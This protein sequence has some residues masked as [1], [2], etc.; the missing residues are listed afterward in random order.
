MEQAIE[1][2]KVAAAAL[3][4][5]DDGRAAPSSGRTSGPSSSGSALKAVGHLP[6]EGTPEVVD[7]DV[8]DLSAVL[9]W[10]GGHPAAVALNYRIPIPRLRRLCEEP[11]AAR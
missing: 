10:G 7:G 2:G 11:A 5:G 9:R 6:L 8:A 4:H 3:V 1:Q